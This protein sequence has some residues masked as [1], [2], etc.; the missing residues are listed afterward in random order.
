MPISAS[1]VGAGT[2]PSVLSTAQLSTT[3]FRVLFSDAMSAVGLTTLGNYLLTPVGPSV[4]RTIISITQETPVSVVIAVNNSLSIGAP[5]YT[6]TV[7]GVTDAAGNSINLSAIVGNQTIVGT[8]GF[9]LSRDGG[10]EIEV[11]LSPITTGGRYKVRVGPTG[12]AIDPQA[13]STVLGELTFIRLRPGQTTA[14]IVAPNLEIGPGQLVTFIADDSPASPP[15]FQ[16]STIVQVLPRQFFSGVSSL[17]RLL[18]S[19]YDVGLID[20]A[21]VGAQ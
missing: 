14:T 17:R 1:A 13:N 18:P 8:T 3:N 11:A 9:A 21:S 4:N 10:T 12:T 19:R 15:S 16:S 2:A 7:T 6:I 5:A 20:P